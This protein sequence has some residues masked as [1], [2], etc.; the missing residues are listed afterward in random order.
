MIVSWIM[1]LISFRYGEWGQLD[2]NGMGITEF[3]INFQGGFVRRGLIGEILFQI[4]SFTGVS[5]YW[6][7]ISICLLCY[8]FVLVFFFRQFGKRNLIW[9]LILSPFLCGMCDSIIRKDYLCYVI[10]IAEMYILRNNVSSLTQCWLAALLAIMGLFAHE[11][12]MFFG[13]PMT[14]LVIYRYKEGKFYRYLPMVFILAS[15]ILLSYFKGDIQIANRIIDSWNRLLPNSP[16]LYGSGNSI[17]A[18][19]WTTK[20]ALSTHIPINFLFKS[21]FTEHLRWLGFIWRALF[22]IASF[23]FIS[24]FL[25][26]FKFKSNINDEDRYNIAA[27]Y[28]FSSICLLPLFLGLSCDYGRIY[29]YAWMSTFI[30]F[31]L[32]PRDFISKTFG[33]RFMKICRHASDRL[34]NIIR[35]NRV[36]MIIFLLCFAEYYYGLDPIHEF[37][38]T[39]LGYILVFIKRTGLLC[40]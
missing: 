30:P 26:V 18:L 37:F 3:L 39:P 33:S 22:Y 16:L 11:A 14:F 10:I 15:F 31:L 32:F 4:T 27:L 5:P 38:S 2:W 9:W 6:I 25:Q 13:I 19:G 36:I 35:P 34:N 21:S 23:Y 29:Q 17:G 1:R 24:N 20:F 7:I 8:V 40:I 28:I 12:F